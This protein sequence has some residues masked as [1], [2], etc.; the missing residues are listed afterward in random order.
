MVV[1]NKLFKLTHVRS[2]AAQVLVLQQNASIHQRCRQ[3]KDPEQVR[4]QSVG[5]EGVAARRLVY[6]IR[7]SSSGLFEDWS[8][9]GQHTCPCS[10]GE[11]HEA[12]VIL[13]C[14]GVVA[15]VISLEQMYVCAAIDAGMFTCRDAKSAPARWNE[16]HLDTYGQI[17]TYK[18]LPSVT[19]I[20]IPSGC[21]P[22]FVLCTVSK[23]RSHRKPGRT[24]EGVHRLV[25]QFTRC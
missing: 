17:T 11:P 10:E 25:L 8:R 20:T 7:Q 18:D 21:L 22:G 12:M 13:I 2:T 19:N 14:S 24:G 15:A 16:E 6:E 23:T 1:R 9:I 4:L 3:E 5:R